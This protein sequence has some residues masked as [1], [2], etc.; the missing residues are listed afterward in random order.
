MS[1]CKV[2]DMTPNILFAYGICVCVALSAALQKSDNS[3]WLA[4]LSHGAFAVSAI[5]CYQQLR[6]D[7]AAFLLVVMS[8][9]LV[10]HSSGRFETID[11]IFTFFTATYAFVTSA[12]DLS[13]RYAAAPLIGLLCVLNGSGEDFN[14]LVVFL[15]LAGLVLL[16]R[17]ILRWQKQPNGITWTFVLAL[18][19]GGVGMLFYYIDEEKYWHS[20]WHVF[21]ALAVAL[22]I[23]P[24]PDND[25]ILVAEIVQITKLRF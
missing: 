9:S 3:D 11:N 13:W 16:Y 20:M 17:V 19:A 6:Y 8:S 15:P 2:N 25:S 4:L 7:L 1:H 10:W 14:Q 22:T 21:G 12:L 18:A 23:D 24:L 5:Y